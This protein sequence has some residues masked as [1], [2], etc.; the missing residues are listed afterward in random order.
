MAASG[1]NM[2]WGR[3]M[4]PPER[5]DPA[6]PTCAGLEPGVGLVGSAFTVVAGLLGELE[7]WLDEF[8]NSGCFVCCLDSSVCFTPDSSCPSSLTSM[9]RSSA[10]ESDWGSSLMWRVEVG[11]GTGIVAALP[12]APGL[13]ESGFGTQAKA[14][15]SF[16][17]TWG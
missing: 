1:L 9:C 13:E 12:L 4:A 8:N 10:S 6:P 2:Y 7:V 5:T 14:S 17:D 15:L 16:G 3:N 11:S